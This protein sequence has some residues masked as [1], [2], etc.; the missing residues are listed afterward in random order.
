MTD[1]SYLE[2]LTQWYNLVFVAVGLTGAACALWGRLTGRDFFR[3]VAG[4]ISTAVVGLTWNGAIHDLGLGSPA[5]RFPLVLIVSAAA[6]VLL[7]ALLGRLRDRYLRP[8]TSVRFNRPGLEGSH[9]RIVTREAGPEPGSG[10][11]QWQD[12]DGVLHIVHVHTDG[13][14]MG[15]GRRIELGEYDPESESYL[16]IPRSRDAAS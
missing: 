14:E 3:Y 6:G 5:L 4:L 11:A 15:F 9:A 7:A 16:A 8:V 1:M 12:S 2:F 10:R 13:I